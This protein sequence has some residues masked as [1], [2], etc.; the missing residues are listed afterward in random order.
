MAIHQSW[1]FA[2][3]LLGNIV[4]FMVYLAPLPTFYQI[5][6]KK[7]SEGFQSVP[8]VVALFS[9]K[10]WIYYAMLKKDA[11]LLI[12]INSVG[13]IIESIYIMLF[14]FYATKKMRIQTVKLLLLLNVFGFSLMLLLSLFLANGSKRILVLGWICLVFNLTVFAAPLCIMRQVVRTKSVEYMPFPLSFFLTIGA[15]TWFF[16]GLFLKDYYIALPNTVGFIFGIVQ[17]ALYV[18][19]KNANK[20]LEEP[21]LHHVPEHIIDAVKLTTIVCSELNPAA[22]LSNIETGQKDNMND[23]IKV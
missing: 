12:T 23:S 8:Y 6:K 9:S 19:Y 20:I 13:C 11:N 22:P 5:Y 21:K 2:F 7:S 18:V 1:A 10:L 15:V 16:Y 4:S 14:I 3:G 17:M